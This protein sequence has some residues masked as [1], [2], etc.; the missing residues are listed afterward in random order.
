MLEVPARCLDLTRLISRSGRGAHTGVDRVEHAYLRALVSDPIPLFLLVRTWLGYLLLDQTGA[1][2]VLDRI[3]GRVPWGA[4]DMLGHLQRKAHPM[5]RRAEADL[6]RL[7]IG[8]SPKTGL[9]RLVQHALPAGTAYIN[10][11]HSNLSEQTLG[12]M[13]KVGSVNV[14]VHDTIPLD[15]PNFQRDGTVERFE[16]K[17]RVVAAHADLVICNSAVTAE[18]VNRWFGA[19]G[20]TPKRTVA[21]LGID[22]H[23]RGAEISR[24]KAFFTV[25]TIEPRKNHAFLL[26]LWDDLRRDVPEDEMP[27]LKIVGARGWKNED[28]FRRLDA[29]PPHVQEIGDM[30]DE[31]L[32]RHLS[33][34]RGLLFPSHAE[35]FG[36]PAVEALSLGVPV[37]CNDLPVF[38]EILGNSPIYAKAGDMYLWKQLI[39]QLAGQNGAEQTDI[40]GDRG[41]FHAPTWADHFNHVLKLV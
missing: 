12:A 18:D 11:G 38:R 17:M 30:S 33:G 13:A 28:V 8:R 31:T 40:T 22:L 2:A 20:H 15:F 27:E 5:K 9:S 4:T 39:L 14:M 26:D 35:G 41:T 29:K 3:E 10:V 6:R 1:T 19:W 36:L 21:R 37:I 34:A 16:E 24:N 32:V 23:P 25:G 7:A